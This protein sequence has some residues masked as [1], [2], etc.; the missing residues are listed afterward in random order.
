MKR[1]VNQH[2]R[3]RKGAPPPPI[4]P[5]TEAKLQLLRLYLNRYLQILSSNP[6]QKKL[7]IDLV[8]GFVGGGVYSG[9]GELVPGSPMVMLEAVAKAD[10]AMNA[11]QRQHRHLDVCFHFVDNEPEHLAYLQDYL[12]RQKI[13]EHLAKGIKYYQGNFRS[14]MPAVIQ[15]IQRHKNTSGPSLFILDQFGYKDAGLH[16]VDGIQRTLAKAE[17]VLTFSYG[18]FTQ[19]MNESD[20]FQKAVSNMGLDADAFHDLMSLKQV[21]AGKPLGQRTLLQHFKSHVRPGSFFTPF[22]LVP[23]G[24]VHNDLWLLHISRH[25]RARDAMTECHWELYN[26]AAHFGKGS[27]GFLGFRDGIAQELFSFREDDAHDTKMQLRDQLPRRIHRLLQSGKRLQ[28]S[29]LLKDVANDTAATFDMVNEVAV[30]L[31]LAQEIEVLSVGTGR[32]YRATV[33]NIQHASEIKMPAQLQ[34]FMGGLSNGSGASDIGDND[35]MTDHDGDYE[36]REP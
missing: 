2:F 22:F 35:A 34:L 8:D 28:W 20:A 21:H 31:H 19:F 30:D 18:K 12:H 5:H 24:P 26:T 36:G 25:P 6:L 23:G 29:A 33:K 17:V 13:S 15:S 1:L 10:A 27:L 14:Q 4:R 3:W 7:T 9:A 32:P 11:G 16:E